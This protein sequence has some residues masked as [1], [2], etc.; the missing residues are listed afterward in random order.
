MLLQH[1][2]YLLYQGHAFTSKHRAQTVKLKVRKPTKLCLK[3]TAMH[4]FWVLESN[5]I[6]NLAPPLTWLTQQPGNNTGHCCGVEKNQKPT[7]LGVIHEEL[8]V[9]PSFL[10]L[11]PI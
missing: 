2:L 5:T 10:W 7:W 11:E 9:I 4:F 3:G 1:L 6:R 8:M